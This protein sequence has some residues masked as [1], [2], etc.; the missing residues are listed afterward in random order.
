MLYNKLL[1]C[2]E[3]NKEAA[4]EAT[5]AKLNC[6]VTK[7]HELYI[8]GETEKAPKLCLLAYEIML[9]FEGSSISVI[10]LAAV[11]QS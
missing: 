2:H 7:M 5:G 10:Y 11:H 6:K 8:Y 9:N 3:Q 4:N 1:R